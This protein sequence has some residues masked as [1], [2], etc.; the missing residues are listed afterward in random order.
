MENGWVKI[1]TYATEIEAE[2]L[3]A[4]LIENDVPAV[5]INK[6]DVIVRFGKVELYVQA[7]KESDALRL[8][9]KHTQEGDI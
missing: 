3:K 7:E 5:V 1:G 9:E 2:I 8:L 4:M 6:Q